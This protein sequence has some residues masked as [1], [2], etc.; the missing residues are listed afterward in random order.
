M[1]KLLAILGIVYVVNLTG[2]ATTT[3]TEKM[4]QTNPDKERYD[5]MLGKTASTCQPK[6]GMKYVG[7]DGKPVPEFTAPPAFNCSNR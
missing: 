5:K 2:C 1:K 6:V 3:E 7:K 4:Y